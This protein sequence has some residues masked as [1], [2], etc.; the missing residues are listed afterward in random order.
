MVLASFRRAP[1]SQEPGRDR[2]EM[3]VEVDILGKR[4]LR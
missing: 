1:L 4:V 2:E 3:S